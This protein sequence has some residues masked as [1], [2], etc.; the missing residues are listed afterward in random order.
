MR[1]SGGRLVKSSHV[2][3]D[4]LNHGAR[5]LDFAAFSWLPEEYERRTF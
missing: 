1:L 3:E 2:N 4:R 5:P